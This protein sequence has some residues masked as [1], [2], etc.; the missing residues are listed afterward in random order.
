MLA[1]LAAGVIVLLAIT[2]GPQRLFSAAI[3][4][5]GPGMAG[6]VEGRLELW[7]RALYGIQDF[8]LT[9]MGMNAFRKRMPVLYPTFLTSPD[10]HVAH[11]HNHLLQAALDSGLPGLVAYASIR[12][13][14]A[15]LLLRVWCRPRVPAHRVMAGGLGAGLIAHFVFSMTDVIPLGSKVGV[16]F[17]L[18]LAL[19][20][21]LHGVNSRVQGPLAPNPVTRVRSHDRESSRRP[22]PATRR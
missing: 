2:L 14:A 8:P 9:G 18:T 15:V 12:M 11:A 5:S 16:L 22:R 4:Q 13:L 21:G 20:V 10:L 7:S 6:N 1:C 17:W 19:T 3:S